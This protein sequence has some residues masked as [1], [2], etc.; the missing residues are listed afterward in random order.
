M[1]VAPSLT[2]HRLSSLLEG[3]VSVPA[4]LDVDIS[5]LALDSRHVESGDLFLAVAGHRVHGIEFA[6]AALAAGAAA[7]VWEP[8]PA[9]DAVPPVLRDAGIPL[10]AV[11]DLGQH[12][13]PIAN[14]FYGYPSHAMSVV[15]IT[16]TDGKTSCSHYIAQALSQRGPVCGL[17]GTLGYGLYGALR[18][19]A[20][21]TPDALAVH[22][23]LAA[24]RARGAI[25]AVMEVSS[26]ALAQGRV[27]GVAFDVAV[28]T[29]LSRDHLDYHG[30]VAAYGDSKRKLFLMPGIRRVV[31]N[32]DDAFG[33]AL[34]EAL[35]SELAITGYAQ[36]PAALE[37][38]CRAGADWLCA[39]EVSADADGLG[40]RILSN[41]GEGKLHVGLL[42][43]F[44]V[45]NLLASLAV[46]LSQGVPFDEAL[47]LLRDTCTVPGRME[48]FGGGSAQAL[49]VVDYAHTPRAL[50]QVLSALREHAQGQLWCVFGAGGERDRGKRP[51]MGEVAERLADHVVVTDDNP[52]HEDASRII[53]DILQ[54]MQDPDRAAVVRDRGQAIAT[55]LA[56]SRAGDVV[57]VAG[58]GHETYQQFGDLRRPYSDR[59]QVQA[60]LAEPSE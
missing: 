8:T 44:N 5:G 20:H 14:R 1:M 28:L 60:L 32:A 59:Q 23:E 55:A 51:M 25:C 34:I 35:P 16:G 49:V 18:Q 54:G 19:G 45:S 22:E 29:N 26:H 50:E 38:L 24:L 40:M 13:G 52:R 17:I 36:D 33:R 4:A 3:L 15:G 47:G 58:K 42:G 31:L 10:F 53:M 2:M 7:I 39:A 6:D 30:D 37:P 46:I 11:A 43:R 12:L 41:G 56:N 27:N 57:L 48:P 21:T 9:L